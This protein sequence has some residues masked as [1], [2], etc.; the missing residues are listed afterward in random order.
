VAVVRIDRSKHDPWWD[1]VSLLAWKRTTVEVVLEDLEAHITGTLVALSDD[2][3]LVVEQPDRDDPD[4]GR[5]AWVPSSPVVSVSAR[6]HRSD[7][8]A[9]V[10]EGPRPPT[11]P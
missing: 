7:W 3:G 10:P 11:G 2:D 4:H 1:G 9:T 5:L 6:Y 8:S